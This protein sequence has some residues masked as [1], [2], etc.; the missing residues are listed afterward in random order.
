MT[1]RMERQDSTAS[2]RSWISMQ[3][4]IRASM[5]PSPRRPSITTIPNP[6]STPVQYP[7]DP[8]YPGSYPYKPDSQGYGVHTQTGY[9]NPPH[10]GGTYYD[11]QREDYVERDT[12]DPE[13][14]HYDDGVSVSDEEHRDF[15]GRDT[16]ITDMEEVQ[17]EAGQRPFTYDQEDELDL[18]NRI[19]QSNRWEKKRRFMGGFKFLKR[20]P[21]LIGRKK[22]SQLPPNQRQSL[23]NEPKV[24]P[25]HA[26]PETPRIRVTQ[27]S[28]D[29]GSH[30]SLKRATTRTDTVLVPPPS[31]TE[32]D[33]GRASH[34][35]RSHYLSSQVG[36]SG[37]HH[38]HQSN[39]SIRTR[40]LS[41]SMRSP[42]GDIQHRTSH[43]N[44]SHH[45]SSH[46]S[47]IPS[48]FQPPHNPPPSIV[49][50]H[51]SSSTNA[52]VI[53]S[54]QMHLVQ[55]AH[56]LRDFH[57]MPWH[58][59]HHTTSVYVPEICS[60]RS[61]H[62]VHTVKHSDKVRMVDAI[63]K[64]S[65]SWYRPS[66]EQRKKLQEKGKWP[67]PYARRQAQEPSRVA[68]AGGSARAPAT[69]NPQPPMPP[70]STYQQTP[71]YLTRQPSQPNA[72]PR[73]PEGMVPMQQLWLVNGFG[74]PCFGPVW[75]MQ[76]SYT[77][78]STNMSGTSANSFARPAAAVGQPV[79]AAVQAPSRPPSASG[80]TTIR[81]SNS[82][83]G[84]SVRGPPQQ[85]PYMFTGMGGMQSPP[86][87]YPQMSPIPYSPVVPLPPTGVP[88]GFMPTMPQPAPANAQA[89][90]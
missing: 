2:R 47:D 19:P 69:T 83:S 50:R 30:G 48:S 54:P 52:S 34:D 15:D 26:H 29:N 28:N 38:S 73:A 81:P 10:D 67:P 13:Q 89:P 53:T 70:M 61:K 84:G 1:E 5:V 44:I 88:A 40:T 21:K 74:Q 31:A 42:G 36:R 77:T 68:A 59:P 22:V 18:S 76:P 66:D 64:E 57:H 17:A 12:I 25:S 55:I 75:S 11:P 32:I 43:S 24:P 33:F 27:F 79:Q 14:T 58:D 82:L 46:S 9:T 63:E 60:G 85:V 49:K 39:N 90:T 87:Y 56:A 41:T 3:N 35:A 20:I 65:N 71:T 45:P 37:S 8:N 78:V 62:R 6:L 7:P 80:R 23:F 4:H 72:V 16:D 86:T 51:S